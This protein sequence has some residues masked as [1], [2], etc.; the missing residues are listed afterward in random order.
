MVADEQESEATLE[1]YV[2]PGCAGSARSGRVVQHIR[3]TLPDVRIHVIDMSHE[4]G[5]HGH[6]V[7]ATPTYVLRGRLFSLGNPR[8][9][10]LE[11]ALR[12]AEEG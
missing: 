9:E 11:A 6:L 2:R 7:V 12:R 1:V 10:D 5:R 3:E 4:S 8:P